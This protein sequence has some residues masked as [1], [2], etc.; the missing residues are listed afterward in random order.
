MSARGFMLC[1]CV[2]CLSWGCDSGG[3]LT[4]AND[5]A[6][7]R[8]TL[9]VDASTGAD[10][11]DDAGMD[12]TLSADT[13][14]TTTDVDAT[15]A[16]ASDVDASLS[17]TIYV[18]AAALADGDGS[19]EAPYPTL[20]AAFEHPSPFDVMLIA[21]GE[22]EPP[23][24][25]SIGEPLTI[26]G[27]GTLE[28]RFVSGE[29]VEWRLL[30]PL[31]LEGLR[32]EHPFSASLGALDVEDV[33]ITAPFR[34]AALSNLTMTDVFIEDVAGVGAALEQ[35]AS[36]LTRVTVRR[37]T[38][39]EA[40]GGDGLVVSGGS[41]RID[42]GSF[43]D[44]VDRGLVALEGAQVEV[45]TSRFVDS[46][47]RSLIAVQDGAV[48]TGTGLTID[49]AGACV[50]GSSASLTLASST[51][52][53]CRTHGILGGAGAAVVLTDMTFTDNSGHI[54]LLNAGSSL[55]L[56]GAV[57]TNLTPVETCI[58]AYRT[59]GL[60]ALTDVNIGGCMGSGVS[61]LEAANASLER[62]IVSNVLPEPIFGVADGINVID[63]A[64]TIMNS[65][66]SDAEGMGIAM[67][68]STVWL[69]GN[70]VERTGSSCINVLDPGADRSTIHDNDLSWC[71]GGGVVI[72]NAQV[73]VTQN[74]ITNVAQDVEVS[75]GE[76]VAFG[77]AAD[78]LVDSNL[79]EDCE[80]NGVSFF[81]GA[82][83]TVSNNTI[84]RSGQSAILEFCT[85]GANTVAVLDNIFEGNVNDAQLCP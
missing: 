56:T 22:Y 7:A 14:P 37:I 32:V 29:D 74:T 3:S 76:G 55:S 77:T 40:V 17:T 11:I 43:S 20:S 13:R 80:L 42:E 45:N 73:D 85:L 5:A 62:V 8:D 64:A 24:S 26:I 4:P 58:S 67:I 12:D 27:A 69:E 78:V 46:T 33:V 71:T 72:F 51:I 60:I 79:I 81:E 65:R 66:V 36:T 30:Q 49:D 15:S 9:S 50:Y 16:D 41:L 82:L 75:L 61:L 19:A 59:E 21:A 48:F 54:A 6:S 57:M 52:K 10:V 2:V 44:F 35:S 39:D 83:G 47:L 63:G 1:L 70:V 25:L 53:N 23:A 34:A 31:R 18:D 84:R 28:T 68:R 38:R